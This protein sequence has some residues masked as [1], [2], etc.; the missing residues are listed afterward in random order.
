[1]DTKSFHLRRQPAPEG[2]LKGVSPKGEFHEIIESASGALL[3]GVDTTGE[4]HL[5]K[6]CAS[7]GL[8]EGVVPEGEFRGEVVG[9]DDC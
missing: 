4:I 1:M 6:Q 3:R 9:K 7:E 8:L 2:L 5:K